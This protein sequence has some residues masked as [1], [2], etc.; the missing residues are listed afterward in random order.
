MEELAEIEI[1][2][3]HSWLKR[4]NTKYTETKDTVSQN[5]NVIS[6][7]KSMKIIVK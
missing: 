1:N 6:S 5:K 7:I 2:N 4:V 3:L